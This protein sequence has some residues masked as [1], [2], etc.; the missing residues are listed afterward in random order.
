MTWKLINR[1]MSVSTVPRGIRLS[2]NLQMVS[3]FS[4]EKRKTLNNVRLM[5]V[6]CPSWGSKSIPG[7]QCVKS[8]MQSIVSSKPMAT[9]RWE[10]WK[11]RRSNPAPINELVQEDRD[12]VFIKI[13]EILIQPLTTWHWPGPLKISKI[14]KLSAYKYIIFQCAYL[15]KCRNDDMECKSWKIG[16]LLTRR[17][18]PILE[19]H[20]HGTFFQATR[21][22]S[23]EIFNG[24]VSWACDWATLVRFEKEWRIIWCCWSFSSVFL[25]KVEEKKSHLS[26]RTDLR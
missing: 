1:M 8:I 16:S 12:K 26:L 9:I 10:S 15:H 2:S 5:Q 13:P 23:P 18:G 17:I 21:E 6:D 11:A 19:K 7:N 25:W 3:E 20:H 4:W 14:L 22:I 24:C